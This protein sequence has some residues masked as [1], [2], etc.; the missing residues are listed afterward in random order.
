MVNQPCPPN[1]AKCGLSYPA[2]TVG[3]TSD[4]WEN[5]GAGVGFG[6]SVHIGPATTGQVPSEPSHQSLSPI[7]EWE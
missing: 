5:P 4:I 1:G 3:I 2:F 7:A 6:P